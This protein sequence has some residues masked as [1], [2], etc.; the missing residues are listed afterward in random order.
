MKKITL[1]LACAAS[2]ATLFADAV[3][4]DGLYYNLD[5]TTQTA[6]VT[7]Q[8]QSHSNYSGKEIAD[9]PSSVTYESKPYKVTSVG[10]H[11][12][13]HCGDLKKVIIPNT[14][15][16]IGK[17]AFE[18]CSVQSVTIGDSV[19]TIGEMAFV[20]C[21]SLKSLTIPNSVLTIEQCA[22]AYTDSL[23]YVTIGNSVTSI[24]SQAFR[25]S[26][27]L[28][29]LIIPNSVQSLGKELCFKCINLETIKFGT[30]L[31]EFD[32]ISFDKCPNIK[33]VEVAEGN[34]KFDSRDNCNAIID[35][36]TGNLV[37][38]CQN[39]IIPNT[40]KAISL[41][42]FY[43]CTGL[44][45]IFIPNSVEAIGSDAFGG[46]TGLQS[47]TISGSVK[48]IAN[49]AFSKCSGLQSITCEAI[50]PPSCGQSFT[51]F[52]VNP[53]IPVHVPFDS[54]DAY[55]NAPVWSDFTNIQPI[56]AS[57]V[58]IPKTE[59]EAD[60]TT[61]SIAWTKVSNAETY[62]LTITDA[63]GLIVCKLTFDAKG[64]LLSIAFGAPARN[65]MPQRTQTSG[66]AFT[67]EGL[68]PNTNYNYTII[69]KDDQGGE[70]NSQ[71]GSFVTKDVPSAINQVTDDESQLGSQPSNLKYFRNGQLLILRDGKTYTVQGQKVK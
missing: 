53:D 30:G 20:F 25:E 62:E 44:K 22:F 52:E 38:G 68:S 56:K 4:I 32:Y 17:Y 69:A 19:T 18:Y 63:N 33:F 65:N 67:V 10:D 14:V 43:N 57:D 48:D 41:A 39:T 28:K 23:A 7:Y 70:L 6:E 12:F 60:E 40:V 55:K 54:I 11:A 26:K 49:Y 2:V 50:T 58:D 46:C 66:F 24:G 37:F 5:E 21:N 27:G 16:T 29:A 8:W 15:K 35:T 42:A 71:T 34:S 61:V 47:V 31:T 64:R 51:F 45:H 36:E 3:K 9:I 13:N 59:V 1:L